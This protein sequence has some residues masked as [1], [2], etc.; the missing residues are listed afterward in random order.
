[1][2]TCGRTSTVLHIAPLVLSIAPSRSMLSVLLSRSPRL[3]LWCHRASGFLVHPTDGC[4]PLSYWY[5]ARPA[6]TKESCRSPRT[7]CPTVSRRDAKRT[8]PRPSSSRA[9]SCTVGSR[10]ASGWLAAGR[11]ARPREGSR[12]PRA[13]R[14]RHAGT[15]PVARSTSRA[16]PW[17]DLVAGDA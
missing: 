1:M 12:R 17:T 14:A 11:S 15:T 6:M 10:S 13:W 8:W 4:Q 16:C 9:A 2:D 7:R 3:L 5:F